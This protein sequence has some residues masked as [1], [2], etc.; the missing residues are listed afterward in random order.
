MATSSALADGGIE[1]LGTPAG[2]VLSVRGLPARPVTLEVY[3]LLGRLSA[4]R[5]TGGET[6]AQIG[7]AG[8]PAGT[9]VLVVTAEGK[10][11]AGLFIHR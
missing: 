11:F 3:D 1:I 4:K 5:R 9:Y 2:E 8:L 7:V 6:D 10:R